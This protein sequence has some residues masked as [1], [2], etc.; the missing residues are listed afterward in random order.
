VLG[1]ILRVIER[2]ESPTSPIAPERHQRLVIVIAVL[3]G[4]QPTARRFGEAAHGRRNDDGACPIGDRGRKRSHF[5]SN[6][7]QRG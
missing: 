6:Q 7:V 3:S 2:A 1:V 4:H 5:R